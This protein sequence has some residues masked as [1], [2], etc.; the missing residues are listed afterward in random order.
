[1][2]QALDIETKRTK[3]GMNSDK[4]E[5]INGTSYGTLAERSLLTKSSMPLP[6]FC[7]ISGRAILIT[8][9]SKFSEIAFGIVRWVGWR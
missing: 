8:Y 1:V 7:R 3:K 4:R 2:Q 5:M 9:T 6:P